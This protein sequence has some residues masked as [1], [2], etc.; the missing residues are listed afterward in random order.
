MSRRRATG[1]G[2]N[3]LPR[4]PSERIR[5]MVTERDVPDIPDGQ[6]QLAEAVPDLPGGRMAAHQPQC[7][8]ESEPRGEQPVHH[9][10]VRV[11]GDAVAILR[12]EQGRRWPVA[13]PP[14]RGIARRPDAR[15][16]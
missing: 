13:C 9:E 1:R 15:L 5:L 12:R 11:P 6:V 7:R 8:F 14:R 2:R 3:A 4:L 10:V 16:A